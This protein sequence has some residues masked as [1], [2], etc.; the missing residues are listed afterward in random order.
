MNFLLIVLRRS[1]VL[2]H[3]PEHSQ[4]SVDVSTVLWEPPT[5]PPE[6]LLAVHFL[7]VFHCNFGVMETPPPLPTATTVTGT[8]NTCKLHSHLQEGGGLMRACVSQCSK[9]NCMSTK[10]RAKNGFLSALNEVPSQGFYRKRV[11]AQRCLSLCTN[12]HE[13]AKSDEKKQETSCR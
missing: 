8:P 6:T 1:T 2:V 13:L 10:G 4:Q 5:R 12:E 7:E 11:S 3:K 9:I